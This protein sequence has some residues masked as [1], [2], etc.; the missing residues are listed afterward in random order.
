MGN[1]RLD[2]VR[3]AAEISTGVTTLVVIAKLVAARVTGSVSILSEALQSTTDVVISLAAIVTVTVASKPAD[4]DHPYGH[5]RLEVLAGAVQMLI[6][7]VSA[8]LIA[9]QAAM[10]LHDPKPIQP[11]LGIW[12]MAGSAASNMAVRAYLLHVSERHG[13]ASIR[14]EAEHLR[15]DAL[16]SVG[17]V[18]GLIATKFSGIPQLDPIFALLFT[19]LGAAYAFKQLMALGHQLMDGALP[20]GDIEKVRKALTEHPHVRDF[21]NLRSRQTGELRIVSLHVLLDD[22]LTFVEAHDIAEDVEAAVSQALGGALVTA[23]YEPYHAELAHQ[24]LHHRSP[25]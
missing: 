4:D 23:H 20:P 5:G 6:I 7:V 10:R 17:V 2:A 9:W 13:S 1:D 8:G 3:R 25:T 11:D 18:A 16:A 14:G 22:D 21:H 12:V 15:A 19:T 24:A